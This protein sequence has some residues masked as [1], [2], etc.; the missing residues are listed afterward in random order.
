MIDYKPV[1]GH[2]TS[3]GLA[4]ELNEDYYGIDVLPLENGEQASIFIIADGMGGHAAG[5]KASQ[6][7][8]NV[9]LEAFRLKG[10]IDH[11]EEWLKSTIEKANQIVYREGFEDVQDKTISMGEE[12]NLEAISA[13]PGQHRGTTLSA[14]L[15]VG[16]RGFIGHV[17]DTRI[18]LIRDREIKQLTQDQ[19]LNGRLLQA[20][21]YR[22][23]VS[24]AT[25]VF[26]IKPGDY[27]ALITD[28]ISR[29]VD[30]KKLLRT[31][32]GVNPSS[33]ATE[34]INLAN[35][36]GGKDNSTTIV[37]KIPSDITKMVS[38]P[39][40]RG[41]KSKAVMGLITIASAMSLSLL[42]VFVVI[43]MLNPSPVQVEETKVAPPPTTPE[44]E[45]YKSMEEKIQDYRDKANSLMDMANQIQ[46]ICTSKNLIV[47]SNE[48]KKELGNLAEPKAIMDRLSKQKEYSDKDEA[49]YHK[50]SVLI[51]LIQSSLKKLHDTVL[52]APEQPRVA[53]Q[54]P[55][56]PVQKDKGEKVTTPVKE[57]PKP[58]TGEEVQKPANGQV[59]ATQ[60]A[61]TT[62]EPK[63]EGNT[64]VKEKTPTTL[65]DSAPSD[66]N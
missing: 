16:N 32:D 40:A 13:R 9:I 38:P 49:D 58:P 61:G 63:K 51:D 43:P 25:N 1:F 36:A 12:F 10:F 6:S 52:A 28:G 15:L 54:P 57:Q 31:I 39:V 27:F 44:D 22:E 26:E 62:T 59:E 18:Y 48:L 23:S 11:E 2:A 53:V 55:I 37:V 60:P 45:S 56:V 14:L 7:A 47:E 20:V 34:I 17:G 3:V 42:F 64:K 29:G 19:S 4:R 46:Q 41:K 35:A 33:A 5:E 24:P 66:G 8:V 65:P 50:A 30:D 21:G